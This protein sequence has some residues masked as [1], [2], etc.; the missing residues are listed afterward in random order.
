M[1]FYN[2]SNK[3]HLPVEKLFT[4]YKEL[5]PYIKL[6]SYTNSLTKQEI[7]KITL[8]VKVNIKQ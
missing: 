1:T 3:L 2:L 4:I 7:E 6:Y 8:S 5:F